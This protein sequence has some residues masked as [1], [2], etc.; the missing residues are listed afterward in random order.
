MRVFIG[1][2]YE[3]R[4]LVEWVTYFINREY[5]GVIEVLPWT[6][7]WAGGSYT[8][9]YLEWVAN[10]T[11]GAILFWT[12]DDK[13]WYRKIERVEPRD[14]LHFEAG[15]FFSAH[16]RERVHLLVQEGTASPTDLLGLTV[17]PFN[18]PN[19]TSDYES[20]VLPR[21]FRDVCESIIRLGPRRRPPSELAFLNDTPDFEPLSGFAAQFRELMPQCVQKLAKNPDLQTIDILVAYRI[22]DIRLDLEKFRVKPNVRVRACLVN[23]WDSTSLD[24]H[25]RKYG[26]N[27]RDAKYLQ[28][29]VKESVEGLLGRCEFSDAP[30]SVVRAHESISGN[31]EIRLTNQRITFA[32]YRLDDTLCIVPLDMKKG[33]TPSPNGFVISKETCPR[34]FQQFIDEYDALFSEADHVF[35]TDRKLPI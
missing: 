12:P 22:G 10:Q 25:L 27:Q 19:G 3:Q 5:K 4:R 23:M 29:R 35:S 2:S 26:D 6:K 14:N 32:L 34:T 20:T 33:Q 13:T 17:K 7:P 8:L 21:I 15:L 30:I 11:D 28:D 16:G 31:Y 1:S 9:E 24:M 18:L